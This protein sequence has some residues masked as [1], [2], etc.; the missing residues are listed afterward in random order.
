[1]NQADREVLVADIND[2]RVLID[3]GPALFTLTE[4]VNLFLGDVRRGGR[5][6]LGGL[7]ECHKMPPPGSRPTRQA[8]LPAVSF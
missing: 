8:E 2:F 4:K 7:S 3:G 1:M 5:F 6:R